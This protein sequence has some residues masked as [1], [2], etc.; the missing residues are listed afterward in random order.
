MKR[1][2]VFW[3]CRLQC[4]TFYVLC[5]KTIS[6]AHTKIIRVREKVIYNEII[7]YELNRKH[8]L[9]TSILLIFWLRYQRCQYAAA[10]ALTFFRERK[11]HV[12]FCVCV[13][14][15]CSLIFTAMCHKTYLSVWNVNAAM[16]LTTCMRKICQRWQFFYNQIA[17]KLTDVPLLS[18]ILTQINV[19][20]FDFCQTM[21]LF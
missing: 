4:T 10:I 21:F 14:V 7:K 19:V 5:K 12:T 13:C 18:K 2:Q 9:D 3:A 15:K 8:P 17:I 1:P 20:G 6:P 16:P 11:N